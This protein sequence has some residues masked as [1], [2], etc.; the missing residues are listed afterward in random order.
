M[1][2]SVCVRITSVRVTE[3]KRENDR[4]E[5]RRSEQQDT[6][7]E[8]QKQVFDSRTEALCSVGKVVYCP[9]VLQCINYRIRN[10]KLCCAAMNR[11]VRDRQIA[12][13][14]T[15]CRLSQGY[16]QFK[17]KLESEQVEMSLM[18]NDRETKHPM[19]SYLHLRHLLDAFP[20]QRTGIHTYIHTLVA[21]GAVRGAGQHIRSSLRF[22]ILPKDTWTCRPG[23]SK[24]C[25]SD[26]K[27]LALPL[28]HNKPRPRDK[29]HNIINRV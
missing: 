7:D 14:A 21:M 4:G 17:T 27:T 6:R 13:S 16:S 29:M 5:E 20:K 11:R 10:D 28:S 3:R 2:I 12:D 22:S 1:N 19:Y 26:N 25:S 18:S 15:G 8:R 24:Q 23:E 9:A